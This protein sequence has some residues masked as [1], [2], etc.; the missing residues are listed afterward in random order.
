MRSGCDGSGG[1]GRGDGGG[2]ETLPTF[3]RRLVLLFHP[4]PGFTKR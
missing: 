1:G 3:L 4:F 2:E